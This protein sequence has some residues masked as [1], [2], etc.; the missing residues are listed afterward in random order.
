[1]ESKTYFSAKEISCKCGCGMLPNQRSFERL[2][3]LRVVLNRPLVI[4]SGARCAKH[5]TAVGGAASS[6]HVT[7]NGFDIKV[8][9]GVE[10]GEILEAALA[11]GFKG[12]GISNKG[13]IH[14]DDGAIRNGKVTVWRYD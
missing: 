2:N 12:I 10:A 6:T 3:A 5:N 4:N 9:N 13:F 7:G 14:V 8:A 1:M 11:L